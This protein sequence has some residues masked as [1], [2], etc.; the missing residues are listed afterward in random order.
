MNPLFFSDDH[1]DPGI[2]KRADAAWLQQMRESVYARYLVVRQ[3]RVMV[4]SADAF[5]VAWFQA[6]E[7]EEPIE[8]DSSTV[9]LGCEQGEPRFA[10]IPT[11]RPV[12]ANDRFRIP[13]GMDAQGYVGLYEAAELLPAMESRLAARAAHLANWI[14]RTHYCGACGSRMNLVDGGYKRV[15]RNARCARE[16]FPRTDPVVITLVIRGDRCLLGRQARF[17]PGRYSTIAGFVEPGES[18]EAA[19]RRE[20]LEEVGMPVGDVRYRGSQ[21]W[22][23]PASLMLGFRADALG[24]RIVLGDGELEDARWFSRED[25]LESI[26]GPADAK[27]GIRLPPK[28]TIARALTEEWAVRSA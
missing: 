17:P 12:T 11:E 23:F 6:S 9:F 8:H 28:G 25:I 26:S 5:R 16:E 1:V 3:G 4:R 15:C 22:P 24:E 27:R 19:V 13:P 2:E 21:P 7:V 14:N 18:L 10:I 20:V